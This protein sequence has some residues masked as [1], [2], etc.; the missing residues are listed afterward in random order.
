MAVGRERPT[1][2]Q[3][4]DGYAY[5][6]E[7]EPASIMRVELSDGTFEQEILGAEYLGEQIAVD[8]GYVYFLGEGDVPGETALKRTPKDGSGE[9]ELLIPYGRG[10]NEGVRE[11]GVADY[12]LYWA[13]DRWNVY[14]AAKD[15]SGETSMFGTMQSGNG[16]ATSMALELGAV[17]FAGNRRLYAGQFGD[18]LVTLANVD[19]E[20]NDVNSFDVALDVDQVYWTWTLFDFVAPGRGTLVET[21]GT[22]ARTEKSPGDPEVLWSSALL[23]HTLIAI[24]DVYIYLAVTGGPSEGTVLRI[25]K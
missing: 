19:S 14:A 15:G 25:A 5:W 17:Y 6:V 12:L 13:G 8:D 22:L 18:E 2:L 3:V 16:T 11:L 21:G 23:V 7:S 1:G 4:N 24:D 10:I 20:A 9:P